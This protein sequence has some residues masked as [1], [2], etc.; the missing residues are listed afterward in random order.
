MRDGT[1]RGIIRGLAEGKYTH[2]KVALRIGISG[3][4]DGNES[5]VVVEGLG[6]DIAML[7]TT[8]DE[9][10]S[11]IESWTCMNCGGALGVEEVQKI[12]EG[13]PLECRYC[14]RVMTLDLYRK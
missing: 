5:K 11:G 7:P 3:P 6:E 4:V 8:I 12:K 14:R 10:S 1:F 13:N 9:I 2:K